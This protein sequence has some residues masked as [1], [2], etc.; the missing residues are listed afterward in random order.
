VVV[1]LIFQ[2]AHGKA[3]SKKLLKDTSSHEIKGKII[4]QICSG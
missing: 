4:S 3:S 1:Y 2:N